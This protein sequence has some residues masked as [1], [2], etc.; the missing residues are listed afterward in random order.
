MDI[1]LLYDTILDENVD[2]HLVGDISY[3]DDY[4]KWEYDGLGKTD[5]DMATHLEETYE[6]DKEI[7]IDFIMQKGLTHSFNVNNIEVFDSSVIFFISEE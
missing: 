2:L 6:T 7:L 3:E 5:E 1:L 4:I